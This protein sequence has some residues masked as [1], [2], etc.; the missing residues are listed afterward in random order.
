MNTLST[1]QA[2]ALA[3]FP[4]CI[5]P[6]DPTPAESS[7]R[8]FGTHQIYTDAGWMSLELR[9]A[10]TGQSGQLSIGPQ[11]IMIKHAPILRIMQF[12]ERPIAP[13]PLTRY[14]FGGPIPPAQV[15]PSA[16]PTANALLS[17]STDFAISC[18]DCTLED[19]QAVAYR[20]FQQHIL[21]GTAHQPP[22]LLPMLSQIGGEAPGRGAPGSD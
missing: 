10:K 17:E 12:M 2:I 13:C 15:P 11:R 4:L 3:L 5:A 1:I 22:E 21:S 9:P 14:D 20:F 7:A 16:S 19:M 18:S 6:P 8:I